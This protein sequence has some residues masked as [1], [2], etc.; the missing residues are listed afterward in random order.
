VIK[1]L[2]DEAMAKDYL[3]I[4]VWYASVVDGLQYHETW[5]TSEKEE[6]QQ[7]FIDATTRFKAVV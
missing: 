3:G 4:M 1:Q 6:S 2:A 5:D 7:A